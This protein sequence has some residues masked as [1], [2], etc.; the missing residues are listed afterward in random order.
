MNLFTQ[1]EG[2]RER[3]AAIK[4]VAEANLEAKSILRGVVL[5][6]ANN[7]P[8][9]DL[10]TTDQVW[11][12]A[13]ARGVECSE[14]RVLGAVMRSLAIT[15]KVAKIAELTGVHRTHVVGGL[16]VIWGVADDND[17]VLPYWTPEIASKATGIEG[18][19]RAMLKVGWLSEGEHGLLVKDFEEWMGGVI[20][21]KDDQAVRTAKSRS[22]PLHD[23]TPKANIVS[24]DPVLHCSLSPSPS[25]SLSPKQQ[26]REEKKKNPISQLKSMKPADID[27]E[28]VSWIEAGGLERRIQAIFKDSKVFRLKS[29]RNLPSLKQTLALAA[30]RGTTLPQV[31]GVLDKVDLRVEDVEKPYAYINKIM[32]EEFVGGMIGA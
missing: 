30:N 6:V 32:S 2:E 10:F 9:G 19:G 27:P 8:S 31:L 29:D 23:V 4:R 21:K 1:A 26:S 28:L 18:I 15:N 20:H 16:V 12:I 11:E 7:P 3:D 5:E 17:G 22:K 25:L 24:P 13:E 14:R